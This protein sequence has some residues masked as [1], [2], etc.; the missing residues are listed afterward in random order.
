MKTRKRVLGLEHPS[1]LTSMANLAYTLKDQGRDVEAVGLM[2]SC[3]ELRVNVLGQSHPDPL[4]AL[5][6][7]LVWAHAADDMESQGTPSSGPMPKSRV[8]S[9]VL[10]QTKSRCCGV[11]YQLNVTIRCCNRH[12]DQGTLTEAE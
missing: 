2:D 3:L 10:R 1:T 9:L 6:T 4:S 11:P 8:D 7:L 12:K 5:E